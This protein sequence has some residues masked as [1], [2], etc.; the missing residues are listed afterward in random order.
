MSKFNWNSSQQFHYAL[1]YLELTNLVTGIASVF[2]Q[3]GQERTSSNIAA[4][5][6]ASYMLGQHSTTLAIPQ[7]TCF[8]SFLK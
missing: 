7:S 6:R 2:L 5:P 4:E 3:T 8:Y 1:E